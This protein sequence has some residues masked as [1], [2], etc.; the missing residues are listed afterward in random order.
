MRPIAVSV[1]LSLTAAA[2]P[3]DAA[4]AADCAT[5][6]VGLTPLTELGTATYLGQFEGGLYEGGAVAPPA[7]LLDAVRAAVQS[8][9]PRDAAGQPDPAGKLVLLS[10]GM[11]NT[12]QEFRAFQAL[13]EGD[14]RVRSGDLLILDGA[15]GGQSAATWDDPTDPNYDR[16]R[17]Q[18]LAPAGATEA[19]VAAVWIKQAHPSPTLSLPDPQAD[20]F[21]LEEDLGQIVRAVKQRYP[22]AA[23]AFLSSRIYAGYASTTLNPEPYAYE[24]GF[25]VKWLI[26]A[27][28]QQMRGGVVDP[29]AGDLWPAVAAP[30]LLWG[31]YLWA[32]GL[33]PRADGLVW[34]CSDLAADGTHPSA[35]GRNKVAALLLE[36]LLRSPASRPWFSTLPPGDVDLDGSVG[37]ADLF[38]LLGSWAGCGPVQLCPADLTGD[39]SVGPADLFLLLGSWGS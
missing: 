39:G 2:Q 24:S 26:D 21:T 22:N 13:V 25:S 29:L 16:V 17:D 6:S 1:V 9:Q 4:R 38:M 28:L 18:V 37:P 31:P 35:S 34:E 36:F 7:D 14:P 32:D 33:T 3:V 15:K 10:I 5:T 20:A 23:I 8:I 27:Q 12:T 11:S 30:L 19:Q